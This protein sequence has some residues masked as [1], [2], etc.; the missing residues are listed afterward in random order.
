MKDYQAPRYSDAISNLVEGQ[1][2]QTLGG[3]RIDSSLE[4]ELATLLTSYTSFIYGFLSCFHC[5]PALN[6]KKQ[7][8]SRG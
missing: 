7:I 2:T 3:Y 4:D 1:F 8:L 5:F 6:N